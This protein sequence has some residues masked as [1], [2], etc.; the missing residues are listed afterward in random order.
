MSFIGVRGPLDKGFVVANAQPQ[1]EIVPVEVE[2]RADDKH[3]KPVHADVS[4]QLF[5]LCV[6]IPNEAVYIV[7]ELGEGPQDAV[8]D[9]VDGFDVVEIPL[10]REV[11]LQ[12]EDDDESAPHPG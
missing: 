11:A 1:P 4:D 10:I 8:D 9:V 6:C 12:N 5:S 2:V 3:A 7:V